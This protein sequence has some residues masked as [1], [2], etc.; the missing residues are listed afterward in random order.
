MKA[1]HCKQ[2]AALSLR[3][4]VM[5]MKTTALKITSIHQLLRRSDKSLSSCDRYNGISWELKEF[6][7]K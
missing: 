1:F 4:I 3:Y 5:N 2:A 6:N 7:Q